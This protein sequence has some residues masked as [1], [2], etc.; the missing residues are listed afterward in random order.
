MVQRQI[1]MNGMKVMNDINSL[2]IFEFL[3]NLNENINR[4]LQ[5]NNNTYFCA[6]HRKK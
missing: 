1:I 4:D 6:M 3:I 2:K 5:V